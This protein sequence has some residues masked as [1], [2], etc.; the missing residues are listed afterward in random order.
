MGLRIVL[1]KGRLVP[2]LIVVSAWV[3]MIGCDGS[4]GTGG[5]GEWT[6]PKET[7]RGIDATEMSQLATRPTTVPTTQSL[8]P[9]TTRSTQTPPPE[10]RISLDEVRQATLQNNLDV[11]VQLLNPTI[12]KQAIS[13]A[14]AQFESV[15]TSSANYSV[16]DT[17]SASQ[18][19]SNQAKNFSADAGVRMPLRTGGTLNFDLPV[20]RTETD[21]Q[22]STL[23][24]AFGADTVASIS[25]PVLRGFGTDANAYAIR[26]AFYQ[27]QQSEART[28]LEVIRLLAESER[29]Y[30]RLYAARR[31]LEVRKQEYDLAVRQLERAQRQVRAQLAAEV[32]VIRAESGVA[33]SL[34]AVINAENLLRNRERELKGIINRPGLEMDTPSIV[35][36][37]SSPNAAYYKL[38][39]QQT[40]QLALRNRME[41]LETEL[42]I[43]Q[44]TANIAFSRNAMLP[45][46][47]L[48]Y[49]YNIN[50]LGDSWSDA[51]RMIR[52]KDYEDH[53]LGVRMEVPIG[54]EAARSRLRRALANRWQQLA[55]K[56]ARELTIEQEVLNAID[57]LEVN[58]QRILASKSRVVLA[59]R[60]LEAE[61]RQF[62]QGLRT[63]TDVLD[64][65]TRLANAQLS[66][67]SAVTEYQIAQIDIAFAT[68]TVLGS[69]RV[70]WQPT[71]APKP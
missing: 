18:L 63:S 2:A 3:A 70:I 50:G 59:G 14:Q 5:T 20:S 42:Q 35:I 28:K 62:S 46:V 48:D 55:T 38:D 64:A 58:Y 31:A 69:S 34:E 65:Q 27:Y 41:L 33:D 16:L 32:E 17:P 71:P 60:T 57:Q 68:G 52:E 45:L 53:R 21:N 23:N 24:P 6:V 30:W 11:Q 29:V 43:A 37:D 47:V 15:F 7:L 1:H 66:E 44:E 8:T 26:V 19:D 12:A 36:P 13:E 49:S 39:T 54:N 10:V 25:H 61:I 22:W 9:A 40:V 67:I 4:F 51:F 56:S